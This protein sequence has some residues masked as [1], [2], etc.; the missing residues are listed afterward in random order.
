[1]L[2]KGASAVIGITGLL[3]MTRY[4]GA[5]QY[6]MIAWTIAFLG[7]FNSIA[8]LGFGS[9]HTKRV[10]EGHDLNECVSTFAYVKILLTS[11]MVLLILLAL[12]LWS[13]W[14]SLPLSGSS[15]HIIL[16]LLVFQALGNLTTI[17]TT[18]FD[19]RVQT[20]KSQ[21]IFLC[22][23]LVR[24]PFL[25]FVLTNGM[26]ATG[27]S[28]AYLVGGLAASTVALFLI[29]KE[30]IVWQRPRLINSYAE[31]AVPMIAVL[32]AGG[33]LIQLAPTMIGFFWPKSEVAF[34]TSASS[35]LS[36]LAILGSSAM[37]LLFPTFSRLHKLGMMDEIKRVSREG[38]RYLS[39]IG[40]PILTMLIVFPDQIAVIMFGE[41]FHNTGKV[42]PLL[43]MSTYIALLNI[44]VSAQVL[45][46]NKADLYLKWM[47]INLTLAVILLT[48][49]VPSDVLGFETLG[50]SY[51]GAAISSVISALVGFGIARWLTF[52]LT[53]TKP[54]PSIL[55][56]VVAASTVGVL[57]CGSSTLYPL[58]HW[59]DALVY[60]L[61]S[62]GGFLLILCLIKEFTMKDYRFFADT[63]NLSKLRGYVIDELL[64]HDR[65]D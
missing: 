38:E 64:A 31:W 61:A 35:L 47:Y 54:N 33:I 26:G 46:M 16:V 58:A 12:G 44:T 23:P 6:G 15:I 55:K 2:T 30:K 52:I 62:I 43:A 8:D 3:L 59:Y 63:L 1:M 53:S 51:F 34:Y 37:V 7:I 36:Y 50:L 14:S 48:V 42:L 60:L 45:G 18:T 41:A 28:Y 21:L 19:A 32:I 56:H 24:L 5:E 11:A 10:S 29:S 65:K 13:L 9:A 39:M 40:L 25:V 27:A 49:L 57:M 17:A 22:D 4:L 20:A